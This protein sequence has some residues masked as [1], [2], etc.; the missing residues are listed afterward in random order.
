MNH[1]EINLKIKTRSLFKGKE[2]NTYYNNLLYDYV[3]DNY[4]D[5]HVLFRLVIYG[6]YQKL[7]KWTSEETENFI[8]DNLENSVKWSD[9]VNEYYY[10]WGKG[11]N[12][13][14]D[15]PLHEPNLDHIIPKSLGGTNRPSNFRIRCA[16]LNENRGNTNSDHERHATIIDNFNDMNKEWQDLTIK[17]LLER[18]SKQI[19]DNK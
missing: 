13:I 15:H 10:D 19:D 9:G 6:Y 16:K 5:P 11:K 1:S 7:Y 14:T 2:D 18:Y 8:S 17:I 12:Q 3:C 4:T